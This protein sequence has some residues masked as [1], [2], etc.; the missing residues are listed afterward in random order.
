MHAVNNPIIH[1]GSPPAY[2]SGA[3][4]ISRRPDPGSPAPCSS[5]A[6]PETASGT[7]TCC[8][9][10]PGCTCRGTDAAEQPRAI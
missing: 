4:D 7:H 10:C 5:P 3:A 8:G 2:E 1:P 6:G 9:N